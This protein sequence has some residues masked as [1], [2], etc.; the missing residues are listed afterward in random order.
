MLYERKASGIVIKLEG[1]LQ[2]NRIF[3]AKVGIKIKAEMH[4]IFIYNGAN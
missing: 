3:P 2:E 4:D 1:Q